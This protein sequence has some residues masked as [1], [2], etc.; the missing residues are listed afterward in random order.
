ME[1]H[2]DLKLEVGT[3]E[4]SVEVTEVGQLIETTKIEASAVVTQ[5]QITSLPVEGRSAVKLALLVPGTSEDGTRARRPGAS[6]G[7]GGISLAGT[8]YIV[9][10]MNNMTL[11]T[12]DSREDIPQAAVQEFRVIVSQYPAEFGGRVG[13]VINVV[14]KSGGNR[15][16]GEAFEF[17]RNKSLNRVDKFQQAQHDQFGTPINN[18]HRNQYG[19][20]VGGPIVKDRI[21]FF[22]SLERRGQPRVFHRQHGKA[23]VLFSARRYLPGRLFDQS[24]A[25]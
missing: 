8:N 12:G 9:D 13:G 15:F 10:N 21:H 16:S 14:T 3:L 5:E 23:T 18:F 11:R 6:V 7:I 17:F 20:S 24:W 4:Q 25:R 2:R 1:F 22:T 19:A